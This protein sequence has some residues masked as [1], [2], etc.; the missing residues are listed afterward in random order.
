MRQV[1]AEEK[2]VTQM[3]TSSTA[4]DASMRTVELI[5]SGALGEITEV[6]CWS[7]RAVWPQGFSRPAGSEPPPATLNWDLWL[8]GAPERPFVSEWP[9]GH[10]VYK[11]PERIENAP[12]DWWREPWS[13][14][15]H[16]FTWRGWQ[17]FGTGA[18]GDIAPH[19]LNVVFWALDLG[20][21]SS[22]EVVETSGLTKE[23]YPTW[24]VIRFDWPARG[25]HPPLTIYW[26]DGGA[27]PPL[28]VR[29]AED[30]RAGLVWIG[31]KG[32]LPAARGPFSGSS[33]TEYER[34][35]ERDW[36][37]EE[38]HLDWVK[39]VKKTAQPGCCFQYAG[40]FTEA[41]LL[42]NVALRVGHVIEWNPLA[43]RVTNC[44]EANRY[45]TREYRKGWDLS[46]LGCRPIVS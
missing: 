12:Y 23:M 38:V 1:A 44:R 24:S 43:F 20:A 33:E 8:G 11:I 35:P 25:L 32:S 22:V 4:S 16:P 30:S 21:P 7:D 29:G 3:G 37:R 27:K 42:G 45:L 41:Y 18:L 9:A 34:P 6:H 28:E 17:D 31:T 19:S 46:Q 15:Y 40:P 5:R 36:G 26:Y 14:V 39:G 13:R 2:V 10:D